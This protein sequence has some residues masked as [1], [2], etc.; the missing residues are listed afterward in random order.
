MVKSQGRMEALRIS[1]YMKLNLPIAKSVRSEVDCLA[2]EPSD[3]TT[4]L[5]STLAVT[6]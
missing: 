6:M 2:V 4:A 1:A 3:E 5:T